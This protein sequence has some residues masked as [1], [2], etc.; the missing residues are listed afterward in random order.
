MMLENGNF[1]F[2]FYDP[3]IILKVSTGIPGR[4]KMSNKSKKVVCAD[5][6]GILVGAP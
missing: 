5:K 3:K 6:I 4:F 2:D 1:L